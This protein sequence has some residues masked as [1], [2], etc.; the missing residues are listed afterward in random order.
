MSEIFLSRCCV[1][2]QD[3]GF[4]TD[5]FGPVKTFIHNEYKEKIMSIHS[6]HSEM[7][8][9][10]IIQCNKKDTCLYAHDE[11]KSCWEVVKEDDACSFHIC[12]DC[13]VYLAKHEDTTLTEEE[14]CS[15]MEQRQK[16]IPKEY[17]ANA[18]HTLICPAFQAKGTRRNS[19]PTQPDEMA[20]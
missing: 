4:V 18:S 20:A 1:T 6:I 13:L 9:W 15:I 14:F 19:L 7:P 3:D 12:V 17:E 8:C 5:L 16:N 10:E 11:K 2:F